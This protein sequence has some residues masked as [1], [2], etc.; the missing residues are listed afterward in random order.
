MA[1]WLFQV[2]TLLLAAGRMC[3]K[4]GV[5]QGGGNLLHT[6]EAGSVRLDKDVRREEESERSR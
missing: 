1:A 5:D 3:A 2:N 4:H 6:V